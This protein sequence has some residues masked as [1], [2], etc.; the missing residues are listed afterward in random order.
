MARRSRPCSRRGAW[1]APRALGPGLVLLLLCSVLAGSL[2]AQEASSS[3]RSEW[4]ASVR[5]LY[6][7]NVFRLTG[8]Q[9]ARVSSGSTSGRFAGMEQPS[10]LILQFGLGGEVRGPGLGARRITA[11]A[12]IGVEAFTSNTQ[13]THLSLET[14]TSHALSS[15]DEITLELDYLPDEFER[16]YLAG[17]DG[18]GAPVYATG[19]ASS[20]EA[21]VVYDR[22]LRDGSDHDL[23]LELSFTGSRRSMGDFAWRERT[24]LAGA[25]ELEVELAS[26]IDAE[27]AVL[28]GRGSYDDATL[29]PY[30]DGGVVVT[31]PLDK[32]FDETELGAGVV[33]DV[34]SRTDLVLSWEH[35]I[36]DYVARLGDDPVYGD[37]RDTRD[38]FEAELRYNIR[39]P[40][41]VRAG[42]AYVAQDTYRPARGDTTDEEDYRAARMFVTLSYAP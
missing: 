1:P 9:K 22:E 35:R 30:L 11:G 42:G 37:R 23:D 18:F 21:R 41:E 3:W 34:R 36:R 8:A 28:R 20:G 2:D 7:S 27:L 39:G 5:A 14:Y 31:A 13:L 32:D 10:D 38:T 17:D 6:D 4:D 19:V 24:E 25:A 16:S 40:L 29:E 33:V 15:R 12:R 26:W